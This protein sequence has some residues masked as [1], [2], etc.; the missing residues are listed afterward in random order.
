M[1][2]I[3][4]VKQ[5]LDIVQIVSEYAKLQK[6]GRNYK[7]SCPFHS[8]KTPSFFVFPEQQSWHCFGACGTGG[9]IFSFV[10]KKEGIDFGQALRV[11]AQRGGVTLSPREAPSKAEDEKRERLFQINEAA[12]EDYYHITLAAKAG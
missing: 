11:L 1:S 12:A 10:M 5:R 2:V 3:D 7:A 6:T 4:D 8:E 9:D